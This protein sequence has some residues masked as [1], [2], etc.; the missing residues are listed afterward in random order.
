MS[1][2]EGHHRLTGWRREA[3][4]AGV[5]YLAYTATRDVQGSASV[6]AT[7]ALANARHV[8]GLEHALRMFHEQSIQAMALTVPLG[9]RF[10]NIFY[11]S[12]HFVVT[13]VALVWLYNRRPDRY[14]RAR[15]VLAL[16]TGLALIG[17]T[18]FPTMPPRLLPSSYGFV[19][20]LARY[21]GLWSFH[22]G[23]VQQLSNQ[24][25]AM[26]SLHFAWAAW[27]AWALWPAVNDRLTRTVVVAYPCATVVA[28]VVTA[29]HFFADVVAGGLTLATA[30]GLVAVV[31]NGS[32][33][34]T[35][36]QR[37]SV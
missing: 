30:V 6:S 1:S 16:T 20:T 18:L 15:N 13:V 25:A 22:S 5:F 33:K 14:R 37:V 24:Y 19:D 21:P 7:K 9:I 3:L 26:P 12:T 32:T 17:F 34:W 2:T 36:R 29:N 27:V 35:S 31:S 11:E 10:A 4:L 28:I 23:A 8:I